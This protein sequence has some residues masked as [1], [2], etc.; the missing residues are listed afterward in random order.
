M[1]DDACSPVIASAAPGDG[2]AV[3]TLGTMALPG[4]LPA[5]PASLSPLAA[6]IDEHGGRVPLPYGQGHCWVA[7]TTEGSITGMIY[8]TPPIRWLQEQ[9]APLR[10]R[11]THTLAEIE[12][13]A[14]AAEHRSLGTGSALLHVA[15]DAARSDGVHLMLA[16]VQIGA[17][18]VMR[19]YR[20]RGYT[21]AAQGEPVVFATQG[22]LTSCDDGGD[23]YQLAVK[24][25]QPGV[26]VRRTTTRGTT[27]L[28]TERGI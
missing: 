19:W 9:P 22:G 2:Q 20:K 8:A 3:A 1:T 11:L 21:L 27:M 28:I 24:A 18:P 14:V 4:T 26:K 5:Q 12:L 6:A 13:L 10:P 15:E 7:R 25:L 23:G 17:F 16:K